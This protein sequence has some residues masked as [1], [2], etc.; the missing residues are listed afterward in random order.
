MRSMM[1][2][3]TLRS[4]LQL[5][6]AFSGLT[7]PSSSTNNNPAAANGLDFSNL[8]GG[9]ASPNPMSQPF[10]NM[11]N[12]PFNNNMTVPSNSSNNN[13]APSEAP[14]ARFRNQLNSL[15]D[16]GF[17]DRSANI[18][19]LVSAHGN[20]NRAIE[21]L[22]EG[23]VSSGD[24][25]DASGTAESSENNE[26]GGSSGGDAANSADGAGDETEG[27]KGTSEKKND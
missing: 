21:I 2:P 13:N 9:G 1:N 11:F 4:M 22:L 12:F 10:P 5:Q 6:Q 17:T 8:L 3:Q 18:N 15:N 7:P 19:A 26:T 24:G 20:V 16:M 27:P 25:A 23:P 14:G